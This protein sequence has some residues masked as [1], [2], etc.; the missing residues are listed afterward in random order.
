MA[1]LN[2]EFKAKTNR[3]QEAEEKLRRFDAHFAGQDNQT[4]TYF[5]VPQGRLKL[6]EG[7][8][9]NA[10]I[11]YERPD[12]AGEKISDTLLYRCNPDVNL[13]AILIKSLGIKI[14][15]SKKRRIYYVGNVKIHFD[16]I[17]SL[18]EFIEVEACDNNGEFAIG[19]LRNQCAQF[20]D[21][22]EVTE[23]D[24]VPFSYSDLL[25]RSGF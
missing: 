21:L 5:N 6:R 10:L 7:N 12:H 22:F 9:E 25:L 15:V 4:D 11:Y 1:I 3:L 8:I 20:R 17:E 18:G 16:R 24:L 19:V 2:V 14:V 23:D 13:K